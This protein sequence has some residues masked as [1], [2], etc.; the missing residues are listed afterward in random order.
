MQTVCL[1]G[2][3]NVGKSSIF[4]RLLK[5]KK[6]IIMD[7]PGITRDRLYGVC[8]Y[9]DKKFYLIDTGGISLENGDFDKDI[10]M[11]A[12]IAMDEADIILFVV[13]GI[14][15]LDATDLYIKDLLHKTKKRV[16][17]VVNKIDNDTKIQNSDPSKGALLL[18]RAVA[19]IAVVNTADNF[20]LNGIMALFNVPRQGQ[21]HNYS[22]S[23]MNNTSNLTEYQGASDYSTPL[24]AASVVTEGQSTNSN[25]I[26]IYESNTLNNTYM[27]IQG[28]YDNKDYYYKM[29]IVD[30]NLNAIDLSRNKSYTFTIIKAKGPGYDTMADAK[31]AK[32]SNV[33]LDF[34]IIV[35]DGDS[36]EIIANNDY[37]LGV[38]NSVYI[39]YSDV[40]NIY[41]AF[42]LITDC[43][44]VFPDTRNITDNRGEVSGAFSLSSP[45]DGKIPVVTGGVA[46]PRITTVRVFTYTWLMYFENGQFENGVEK[47]NAYITLKLG[48]L[49][50]QVHIRQRQAIN[51]S[52]TVLEYR[53]TDSY[54]YPGTYPNLMDYHCLTGQV[55]DGDDN[56]KNWIKLRPSTMVERED[57]ERI[58][59]EDGQIFIEVLPNTTNNRRRGTVYLTTVMSNGSSV[60]G[61]SV[62]R[63]KID[64]TQK[65]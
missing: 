21:L 59:V 7:T 61:S 52:G 12:Q 25:P 13:D 8:E 46:S 24:V 39:T 56:P 54:P 58:I 31:V 5:E 29:A 49:E 4:N 15:D 65:G 43:T 32:P 27:I 44:K 53:P 1:I 35:D 40:D 3:P 64:I 33:D 18:T 28:K 45:V 63:I 16:I 14:S 10:I 19:R 6:A 30:K 60:G 2:K 51:A 41:N 17:V 23:I 57:T 26:Y 34:K 55:E 36:Y 42:D 11:Q 50:K 47:N 62:K 9:K 20:E 22:N 38:S 37:Y 48:N